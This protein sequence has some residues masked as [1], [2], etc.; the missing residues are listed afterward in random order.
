[1]EV[2]ESARAVAD[3]LDL[4]DTHVFFNDWVAYDERQNWLL[5]SDLSLSL[6][7]ATVEARYAYRTRMLDNIWC[8]LPSVVTAGDVLADLIVEQ[9]IGEVAPPGDVAAVA[10]A[11]ERAID[12]DRARGMRANLATLAGRYT[13]EIV[14]KPL[15]DYCANPWK[16]GTSRG[17]DEA[18]AYL[19][20]LERLYSETAGY[21]RH[22][23]QVVGEK[24]RVLEEMGRAAPHPPRR[25][26]TRPDLGSLFRRD[27]RG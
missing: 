19:H 22:L 11:I 8:G 21:A 1:M 16:L 4:L 7:V 14:S 18:A 25:V 24:D 15:L 10:A 2:V 26:L 3:E 12:R 27:K 17:S 13:W 6:H 23:E 20:Q 5:E 9:D